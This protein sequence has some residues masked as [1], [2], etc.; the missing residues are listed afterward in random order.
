MPCVCPPLPRPPRSWGGSVPIYGAYTT[1]IAAL[2]ARFV[3][4]EVDNGEPA[5]VVTNELERWVA[6]IGRL[7]AW[8]RERLDTREWLYPGGTPP[9]G[10]ELPPSHQPSNVYLPWGE[11]WD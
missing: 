8:M 4:M 1:N 5:F 9:H 11:T 10:W 3:C 2:V 6:N 7:I